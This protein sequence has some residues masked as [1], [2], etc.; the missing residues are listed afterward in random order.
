MD[1]GTLMEE[2]SHDE[3]MTFRGIYY[4]LVQAQYKFLGDAV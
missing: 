1:H 3:L 2:G 4:G